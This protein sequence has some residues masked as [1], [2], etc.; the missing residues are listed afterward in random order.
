MN[1]CCCCCCCYKLCWLQPLSYCCCIAFACMKPSSKVPLSLYPQLSRRA[2]AAAKRHQTAC[3][4]TF[5]DA[6]SGALCNYALF[7]PGSM[8]GSDIKDTTFYWITHFSPVCFGSC[9]APSHA[10]KYIEHNIYMKRLLHIFLPSS[11]CR[12]IWF[13]TT[14]RA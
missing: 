14:E 6:T 5:D 8:R 4:M 7:C 2:A 11:C 3:R 13:A 9:R 10:L 12:F 1:C